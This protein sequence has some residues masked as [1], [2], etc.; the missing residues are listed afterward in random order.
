MAWQPAATIGAPA[1]LVAILCAIVV[2]ALSRWSWAAPPAAG[3]ESLDRTTPRRAFEGFR[4]AASDGD[5]ERAAK[6]LDLRSMSRAKAESQGPELA[7]EL[8][9]VIERR[10]PVDPATIPDAPD[11]G[12]TAASV[13]VGSL[14]VDEEPIYLNLARIKFA[15]GVSRWLIA[16]STVNDIP[17]LDDAYGPKPWEDKIPRALRSPYVLGNAPWQWIGLIVASLAGIVLG[18][19]IAAIVGALAGRLLKRWRAKT[20]DVRRAEPAVRAIVA[21]VAFRIIARALALTV[22]VDTFVSRVTSTLLVLLVAWLVIRVLGVAASL[23]EDVTLQEHKDEQASRGLRTQLTI[24]RR[25][26]SIVVGVL[27]LAGVLLQFEVVRSVGTSLLASAGVAGIVLGLAAQKSLGA[28]IAG[29]QL[30]LAQPVRIGDTVVV[31]GQ[32]GKVEELHLTYVVVKLWDERR[33]IVPIGKFLDQS[34]ENW[35]K[36]GTDL[37]GEVLL[38]VD[39]LAPIAKLR[40]ELEKTCKQSK[41]WDERVCTLHVSDA[42]DRGIVLRAVVSARDAD[43]LL[44]LRC[45][46]REKLVVLAASIDDGAHLVRART[47]V[48]P[49]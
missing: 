48:R 16:K 42:L 35:T 5:Y 43:D 40:A 26:A 30:S 8:S 45:L 23:L 9:Y 14:Y 12:G 49:S 29:I 13:T 34:F 11:A 44:E 21:V 37:R 18:R 38:T 33:L 39:Y 17:Q 47:E 22:E 15:D 36:Q 6:Y 32:G 27:A 31:D 1:R 2:L 25:I 46:V 19:V 41:L 7:R 4:A 10:M 20:T 24:L 3:D 28:I